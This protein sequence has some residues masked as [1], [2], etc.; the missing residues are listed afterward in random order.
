MSEYNKK[1]FFYD[2][3]N[4]LILPNVLFNYLLKR[5]IFIYRSINNQFGSKILNYIIKTLNIK[6][7][8]FFDKNPHDYIK[9]F[10]IKIVNQVC[11]N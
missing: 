7:L 1:I 2:T 6:K 11:G 9:S 10:D 5:K 8:N 4:I 3:I